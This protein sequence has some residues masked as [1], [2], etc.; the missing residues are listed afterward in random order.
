MF[1]LFKKKITDMSKNELTRF[2]KHLRK[3]K[4][5]TVHRQW[6]GE[7]GNNI[8]IEAPED[9]NK[10]I[11]RIM[12]HSPNIKPGDRI[13]AKMQSGKVADM[14]VLEIKWE[15]DPHDMFFGYA[16]LPRYLTSDECRDEFN[17]SKGAKLKN[18]LEAKS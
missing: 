10:I 5:P 4:N 7:W 16:V 9:K 15:I 8:V 12:G 13:Y 1:K 3:I 2:S 18:F 14:I 11:F 17:K 6:E